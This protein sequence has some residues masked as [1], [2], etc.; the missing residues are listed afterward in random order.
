MAFYDSHHIL[1]F[2]EKSELNAMDVK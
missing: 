2:A 1:K